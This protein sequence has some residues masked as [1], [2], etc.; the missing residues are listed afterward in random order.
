MGDLDTYQGS[1][2]DSA[3]VRFLFP[4]PAERRAGAILRWWE[5]RRIQYNLVVGASGL[6]AMGIAALFSILPPHAPGFIFPLAGIVIV[7]VMANICYS[8]GSLVE[9]AVHKLWGRRVLPIGPTLFRQ[10]IFFSI[11]LTLVLPTIML[12]LTWLVRVLSIPF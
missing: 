4:E 8:L 7:G 6:T 10:G 3:L 1:S 11:G 9:I 5:R 2:G 12:T